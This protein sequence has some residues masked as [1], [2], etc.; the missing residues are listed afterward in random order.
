[1]EQYKEILEVVL[2]TSVTLMVVAA[3][4]VVVALMCRIIKN[5]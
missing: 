4:V 1:M 2:V 5:K 3:L